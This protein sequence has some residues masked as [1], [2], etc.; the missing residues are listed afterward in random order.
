MKIDIK[1]FKNKSG[2]YCIENTINNKKYIGAS[3]NIYKR[4]VSHKSC[5]NNKKKKSSNQ[6][7]IDEWHKFGSENFICYI[8]KEIDTVDKKELQKEEFN[9][10]NLLNTIDF[11]FGY[12]LR[13]DDNFN[14]THESTL[15]KLKASAKIR[16]A[17]LTNEDKEKTSLFFK[18]FWK[19]NEDVKLEMSKKVSEKKTIYKIF[20]M[21]ENENVIEEF[22]CIKDVIDKNPSYKWQNI[23]SA[24][25][26][27]K[28]RI[29]GFKWKKEL[30]INNIFEEDIVQSYEKS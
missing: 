20:K 24:C 6:N 8:I 7:M 17:K 2:I 1:L 22:S 14:I 16:V 30:I 29:Y 21:D 27:Y 28:K 4:L 18:N 11:N 10:I 3:V 9:T 19:E 15:E 5:L 23:Y 12:N 13:R 26:G 25:N